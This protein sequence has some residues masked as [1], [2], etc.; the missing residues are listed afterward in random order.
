MLQEKKTPKCGKKG[1]NI[2][3]LKSSTW[4]VLCE[5]FAKSFSCTTNIYKFYDEIDERLNEIKIQSF[6]AFLVLE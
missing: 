5:K 3:N 1:E 6:S 4:L 2:L